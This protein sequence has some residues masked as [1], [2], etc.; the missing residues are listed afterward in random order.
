MRRPCSLGPIA[1]PIIGHLH[2]VF[3]NRARLYDW[4]TEV[5][6]QFGSTW[7]IR[8]PTVPPAIFTAGKLVAYFYRHE[9]TNL[10][11][12]LKRPTNH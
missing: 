4:L 7:A 10:H 8:V 5:T 12:A 6:L 2:L 11:Q 9:R 3:Q 1:L